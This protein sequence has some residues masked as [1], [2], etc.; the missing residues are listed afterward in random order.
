[1]HFQSKDGRRAGRRRILTQTLLD[2][3]TIDPGRFHP[4][5][6]FALAGHRHIGFGNLHHLRT[7]GLGD[8]DDL[9]E[10]SA[11]R[12]SE[13][14]A[15]TISPSARAPSAALRVSTASVT[16]VTGFPILSRPRAAKRTQISVTTP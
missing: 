12:A 16:M 7:A 8:G 2:I 10:K 14:P 15:A 11:V 4:D 3:R 1:G 6:H 5:E 13:P 9:H